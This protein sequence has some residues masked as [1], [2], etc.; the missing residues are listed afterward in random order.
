MGVHS[1]PGFHT[2]A[3][4]E[5]TYAYAQQKAVPEDLDEELDEWGPSGIQLN[6]YPLVVTLDMKGLQ[7][8]SDFDAHA[9]IKERMVDEA[10]WI[11]EELE[12]GK[13]ED[14]GD[15][16]LIA[17]GFCESQDYTNDDAPVHSYNV[18]RWLY[19]LGAPALH[20][21]V[22]ALADYLETIKSKKAAMR[23]CAELADGRVA[24]N[25]LAAIA[26]QFRY[27]EDVPTSRIVA[28]EY[29]RPIF[30]RMFDYEAPD[31]DED[32]AGALEDAGWAVWDFNEAVSDTIPELSTTVYERKPPKNARIE[33]HG[34]TY[35]NLRAAAPELE[36]PE[37][38]SPYDPMSLWN[39]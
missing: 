32:L 39:R 24:D 5:T 33:Y 11:V 9:F 38:P 31:H 35:R 17:R 25:A 27:L 19:R 37:P 34:T 13:E 30:P 1:H 29:L 20:D 28:V 2:A 22:C 18:I 12:Y 6:D 26:G 16:R 36:L 14:Q 4:P 8:L 21:P 15:V 3:E 23:F 10:K 7:R